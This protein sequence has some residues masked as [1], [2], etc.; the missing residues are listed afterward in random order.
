MG[1]KPSI[2][3]FGIH[4]LINKELKKGKKVCVYVKYSKAK[5]Q[6]NIRD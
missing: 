3:S 2:R 5:K 4:K 6:N 1:G